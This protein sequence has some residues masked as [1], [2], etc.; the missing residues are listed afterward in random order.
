MGPVVDA[1]VTEKVTSRRGR[2][3]SADL[4]QQLSE[5]PRIGIELDTPLQ[6]PGDTL[7][8]ILRRSRRRRR[9]ADDV[10][11]KMSSNPESA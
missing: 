5:V 10:P 7:T 11:D 4:D 8:E 9:R 3:S 1:Q 6:T 2:A